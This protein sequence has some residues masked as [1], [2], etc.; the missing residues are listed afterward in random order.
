MEFVNLLAKRAEK[1][2]ID[3]STGNMLQITGEGRAPR[4]IFGWSNR[5]LATSHTTIVGAFEVHSSVSIS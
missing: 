5:E 1:W 4:S 2:K 3:L